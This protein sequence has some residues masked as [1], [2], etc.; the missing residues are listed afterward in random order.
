ME[1]WRRPSPTHTAGHSH[2]GAFNAVLLQEA[3]DHV[4]HISDQFNTNSVDGG[5]AILF[6][7]DTFLPDA[8][9][10]LVIEEGSRS[11]GCSWTPAQTTS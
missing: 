10:Y 7:N 11:I 3:H 4:P 9:K 2:V 6:N 1:R 5:L 8:V